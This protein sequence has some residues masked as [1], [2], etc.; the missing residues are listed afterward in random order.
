MLSV[1]CQ[2][3]SK[4][5]AG[6]EQG[7]TTQNAL[8]CFVFVANSTLRGIHGLIPIQANLPKRLSRLNETPIRGK[9]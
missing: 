9:N 7:R 6:T 3:L 5:N 2:V 4:L 8:L 1:G